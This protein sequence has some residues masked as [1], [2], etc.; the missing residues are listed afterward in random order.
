VIHCLLFPLLIVS[1]PASR[2]FFENPL[3]E[4]I[5]L[6]LGISIGAVSFITSYRQHRLPYPLMLGL[7]GVALLTINLFVFTGRH[8]HWEGLGFPLDPFMVLGGLLLIAGHAWNIHAC[9]CFCAPSCQH[10]ESH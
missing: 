8:G 3:L 2:P 5:I 1:I 9:H 10:K 7:T 6:L 4:A